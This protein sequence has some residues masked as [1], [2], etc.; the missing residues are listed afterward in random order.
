M[1]R[2]ALLLAMLCYTSI[3]AALAPSHAT[4]R[5][6]GAVVMPHL[7][8]HARE[9]AAAVAAALG[10]GPHAAH[11]HPQRQLLQKLPANKQ[12]RIW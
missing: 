7:A 5:H 2:S 8:E 11:D 9:Q 6:R 3:A 12:L 4:H 10:L 1:I